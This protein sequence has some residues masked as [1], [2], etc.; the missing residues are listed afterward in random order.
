MGYVNSNLLSLADESTNV[1]QAM[2][3]QHSAI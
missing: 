1:N 3:M 2:D